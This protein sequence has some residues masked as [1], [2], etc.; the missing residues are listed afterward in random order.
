MPQ[1]SEKMDQNNGILRL[2]RD[3]T[4]LLYVCGEVDFLG[5]LTF[6]GKQNKRERGQIK[7]IVYTWLPPWKMMVMKCVDL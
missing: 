6:S 2:W 5:C 7:E 4:T 3:A 1:C